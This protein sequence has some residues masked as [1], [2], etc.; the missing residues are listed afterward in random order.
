MEYMMEWE[1]LKR[2]ISAFLE[3][4]RGVI[5]GASA[6]G[7]RVL[8][9]IKSI[10]RGIKIVAFFDNDER[11]WGTLIEGIKVFPPSELLA[12]NPDFIIVASMWEDEIRDQL[13]SMGY[14]DNVISADTVELLVWGSELF[15][16]LYN[17]FMKEQVKETVLEALSEAQNLYKS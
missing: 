5:F 4:K 3:G 7:K 12:I 6:G 10:K 11:K 2:Q 16:L 14:V 9:T 15:K 17:F 13:E 1:A 8:G